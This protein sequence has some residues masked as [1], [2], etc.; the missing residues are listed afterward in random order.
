MNFFKVKRITDGEDNYLNRAIGY[1]FNRYQSINNEKQ[2][3][4]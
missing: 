4:V 1:Y 3:N 2:P